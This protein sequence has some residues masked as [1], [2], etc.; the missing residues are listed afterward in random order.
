MTG[1]LARRSCD[2]AGTQRRQPVTLARR[3]GIAGSPQKPERS[4]ERFCPG[5]FR[6]GVPAAHPV[7]CRELDG[8]NMWDALDSGWN[9][10]ASQTGGYWCRSGG[11]AGS[12]DLSRAERPRGRWDSHQES[13][14][15]PPAAWPPR[16]I[17][18]RISLG[19]GGGELGQS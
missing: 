16:R 18:L 2:H 13:R 11:Q 1:R 6:E 12:G 3:P 10:P 15:W 5:A 17:R 14:S 7:G 4:Q 9:S 8:F 19:V